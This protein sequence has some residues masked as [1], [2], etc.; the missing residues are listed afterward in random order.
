MNFYNKLNNIKNTL[1]ESM[2]IEP[3]ILEPLDYNLRGGSHRI[4]SPWIISSKVSA[5][6]SVVT[7]HKNDTNEYVQILSQSFYLTQS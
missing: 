2:N 6:L 7:E 5:T 4:G 1:I 3:N